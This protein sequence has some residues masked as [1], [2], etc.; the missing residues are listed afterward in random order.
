[1][2]GSLAMTRSENSAGGERIRPASIDE[3]CS[4]FEEAW[5]RILDQGGDPPR[6]DDFLTVPAG[7]ILE[8]EGGEGAEP[9]SSSR[10]LLI[11]LASTDL[12]YR[13][14]L[15]AKTAPAD[16]PR[17]AWPR[18]E[19]Y[20]ARYPALGPLRDLP[21][22]VIE[23][24]FSVR[25]L[26]G[27][28]PGVEEYLSRFGA[29]H[30]QLGEQLAE[31]RRGLAAARTPPPP[32]KTAA[33]GSL[34]KNVQAGKRIRYLGDY[35]LLEELGR[36]GMGVV[37][38][39]RQI[40]LN[41][42]VAV[43]MILSGLLASDEAVRRFR[44]EAENAA[45][46]GHPGI[47]PIFEVGEHEGLH[48]FS[49]AY[50]EGQSLSRMIA[51]HPL[52]PREAARIMALT[53]EAVAFAHGQGVIHRDLKPANILIDESGKPRITDFGLAKRLDEDSSFSHSGAA[54]GTPS[55]MPPEQASGHSKRIDARSDVYSLGATLYAMLSGRPPFQADNPSDT[56]LQV[57]QQEPIP[58]RQLNPKVPRDLETICLKCLEKEPRRRY[59]SA[60][61]YAEEIARHLR[62]EP[63]RARPVG[64]SERLWRWCKRKPA[65]SG[66]AASAVFL[67]LAGVSVS[68]YFAV[69]AGTRAKEAVIER[70]RADANFQKAREAVD[71]YFTG[72]SESELLEVPGLQPL[73]KSLL[74]TAL[75]Y[76][77]GFIEQQKH[78]PELQNELASAYLRVAEVTK[79]IGTKTEALNSAGKACE[80]LRQLLEKSPGD[81][82]F[83]SRL[84]KSLDT[85]A[86]LQFQVGKS[87]EAEANYQEALKISETVAREKPENPAFQNL[88]AEICHDLG[89]F[90]N[91]T[92]R[93]EEAIS[94]LHQAV[95][96]RERLS[97]KNPSE[98][99]YRQDLANDYNS[100]AAL[101]MDEGRIKQS[102][103]YHE[104][105]V[106]MLAELSTR[107]PDILGP[108]RDL[109]S[110]LL[111]YGWAL[112]AAGHNEEATAHFQNAVKIINELVEQNP[113]VTEFRNELAGVREG[114]GHLADKKAK[115]QEAMAHF[116]ESLRIRQQVVKDDPSK[117]DY[118]NDLA[119]S[120][121]LIAMAQTHLG[122]PGKSL[123]NHSKAI[124]ILER[125][126]RANPSVTE[127]RLELASSH[128]ML[129]LA[130]EALSDWV[131][132]EASYSKAIQIEKDLLAQNPRLV[133]LRIQL[134]GGYCNM[135]NLLG[136]QKKYLEAETWYNR[137]VAELK[138]LTEIPLPFASARRFLRNVYCGRAKALEGQSRYREAL[139]DWENVIRL[140][141]DQL[142]D[143]MFRSGLAMSLVRNG[144]HARATR[145]AERLAASDEKDGSRRYN[146]ACIWALAA[147]EAKRDKALKTQEQEETAKKYADQAMSRLSEAYRSGLFHSPKQ[148]KTL[149]HDP[150]LESLG[151]RR[152]FQKLLKDVKSLSEK[153]PGPPA[154]DQK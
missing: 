4:R 94:H 65:V 67:L 90:K 148:A 109:G 31:V 120:Y 58:L 72:V 142:L 125:L 114:L 106:A 17:I 7:R 55:Y 1:M 56:C 111:V 69:E 133:D 66:L 75:R 5:K 119:G 140:N 44:S 62:G 78:N 118:Q 129:G 130:Q 76:Y 23:E 81:P 15:A 101:Q 92:A 117:V 47:V 97:R 25:H 32:E 82:G 63:I 105:A 8:S 49:M 60:R 29:W 48:Y 115:R 36:G 132:A 20:V 123:Q 2:G 153:P 122:Q 3:I 102:L 85:L 89:V 84:A 96:I 79:E 147:G 95:K 70:D 64:P 10:E 143:G 52:P 50:V 124:E 151:T 14:R 128:N 42:V 40:S 6:I 98:Y 139:R 149:L 35:E 13:W 100:L 30:P 18:V 93:L 11:D 41:R 27:D 43:K 9:A 74:E 150:D 88:F 22:D 134:G 45:R 61:E 37:F 38:K 154:E 99:K 126:A 83:R 26:Y 113:S 46:L 141:D 24:E 12:E 110:C 103:Q 68:A 59:A 53:A 73:R 91:K 144:Q 87:Q 137:A 57:I 138:V 127:Y 21:A 116:E 86:N 51:E 146:L 39:A 19:D 104:Q 107:H 71:K 131:K 77:N 80:I 33:S 135:G 112:S 28:R 152:D 16:A 54:I 34:G 136:R 108:K 121:N 145:E